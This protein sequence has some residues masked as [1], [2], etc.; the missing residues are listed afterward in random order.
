MDD[1]SEPKLRATAVLQESKVTSL[2]YSPDGHLLLTGDEDGQ[3]VVWDCRDM[4]RIKDWSAHQGGI[5]AIAVSPTGNEIATGSADGQLRI[6]VF[7]QGSLLYELAGHSGRVVDLDYTPDGSRLA[8]AGNEGEVQLWDTSAGMNAL[9][10]RQQIS[11]PSCV[12]FSKDGKRLISGSSQEGLIVSW[13]S[14]GRQ[15]QLPN[16]SVEVQIPLYRRYVS[17]RNFQRVIPQL[18]RLLRLD[19]G[20]KEIAVLLAWSL[21]E[22]GKWDGAKR[23]CDRTSFGE[24]SGSLR[25]SGF[26]EA[27]L[28]ISFCG[29]EEGKRVSNAVLN[30]Y[31]YTDDVYQSY[32]AGVI[33]SF[34]SGY[35]DD[36]RRIVVMIQRAIKEEPKSAYLWETLAVAQL[37]MGAWQDALTSTAKHR[38]LE[39]KSHGIDAFIEAIAYSKMNEP[40]KADD[41]FT[42]GIEY[43][44]SHGEYEKKSQTRYF[45]YLAF[46][47]E[48][49]EE[50][51]RPISLPPLAASMTQEEIM[52]AYRKADHY[53]ELMQYE[54]YRSLCDSL[55]GRLGPGIDAFHASLVI[56]LSALSP[57]GQRDF[58][59]LSR[60][61]DEYTAGYANST[62]QHYVKGLLLYR[63]GDTTAALLYFRECQSLENG[64]TTRGVIS[65]L[66]ALVLI[67]RGELVEANQL[68]HT[69]DEWYDEDVLN[70]PTRKALPELQTIVA[71]KILRREV[72]DLLKKPVKQ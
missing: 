72:E 43:M 67:E 3:L 58:G 13:S 47:R 16:V 44:R 26:Y 5:S 53:L 8:S 30:A 22:T 52:E 39:K 59:E 49:A 55:I 46:C 28:R 45:D 65:L 51:G 64:S 62:A 6:W 14:A 11:S 10:L 57:Y 19:P 17:E 9:T 40:T 12:L 23:V 70:C 41:A 32:L 31:E 54:S 37:R 71:Y 35:I 27:W 33:C 61:A 42:S 15:D 29:P 66:I 68:I 7:P 2:K 4:S 63:M 18:E 60:L 56:R 25:G 24:F 38:E 1:T 48:A 36:P 21:A 20:N 34:R 50:I 69:A